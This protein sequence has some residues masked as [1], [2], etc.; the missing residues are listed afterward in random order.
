MDN[1]RPGTAARTQ[2]TAFAQSLAEHGLGEFGSYDDL[3]RWSTTRIESLWQAVAD[4]YDLHFTPDEEFVAW[5]D[6]VR[7]PAEAE[8]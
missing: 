2:V 7:D 1:A 5:N 6:R 4:V 3:G 8:A